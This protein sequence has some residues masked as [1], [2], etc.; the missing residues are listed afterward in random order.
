MYV[1]LTLADAVRL[2]ILLMRDIAEQR[3]AGGGDFT[4]DKDDVEL[5]SKLGPA[6]D[7]AHNK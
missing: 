4:E 3:D 6:A 7:P 2:K 1:E 5:M